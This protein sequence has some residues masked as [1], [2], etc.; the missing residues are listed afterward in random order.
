MW[1]IGEESDKNDKFDD[2]VINYLSLSRGG[3]ECD[4]VCLG[5]YGEYEWGELKV[6]EF[7]V[8][9]VV[10][11]IDRVEVVERSVEWVDF[12]GCGWNLLSMEERE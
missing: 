2:E 9:L 6:M 7:L 11:Y 3:V 4:K 1:F 5:D 12:G 10:K 8:V